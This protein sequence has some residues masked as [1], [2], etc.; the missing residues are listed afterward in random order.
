MRRNGT[1]WTILAS[2]LQLAAARDSIPT[3]T[4]D[5]NMK[6]EFSECDS[7]G[8]SRN[9]MLRNLILLTIKIV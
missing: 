7:L 5:K 3:C 1:T 6:V 4:T 8:I 2:L 9:G